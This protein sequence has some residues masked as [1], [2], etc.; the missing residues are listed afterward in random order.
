M[1]TV[2]EERSRKEERR[3]VESFR[4][5][6][7]IVKYSPTTTSKQFV[8]DTENVR[9]SQQENPRSVLP[10]NPGKRPRIVLDTPPRYTKATTTTTTT[11]ATTTTASTTTTTTP[12]MVYAEP[13]LKFDHRS[14]HYRY[15]AR[16]K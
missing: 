12:R 4:E 9:D 16:K 1:E 10:G 11:T 6:E 3:V 7:L 5:E 13:K 15:I 8:V 14:S 2:E